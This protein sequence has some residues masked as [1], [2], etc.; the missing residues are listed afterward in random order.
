M[1]QR[2]LIPTDGSPAAEESFR[3]ACT[4]NW[5]TGAVVESVYVYE[6]PRNLPITHSVPDLVQPGREA[7]ARIDRIA[8]ELSVPV[9]TFLLHSRSAG[10]A[11][12]ETARDRGAELIILG[13]HPKM[14]FTNILF[15]GTIAFVYRKAP[16]RV[17]VYRTE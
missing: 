9:T 12:V 10:Q 5:A 6:V 3:F 13:T 15:G 16:C 14:R 11:I 17:M 7:L 8:G 2:I 1:F 4:V